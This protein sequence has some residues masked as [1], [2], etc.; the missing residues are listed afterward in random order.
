MYFICAV[1]VLAGVDRGRR[2]LFLFSLFYFLFNVDKF[3]YIHKH[4]LLRLCY[5]VYF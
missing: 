3:I 2:I 4:T 5:Y 1:V